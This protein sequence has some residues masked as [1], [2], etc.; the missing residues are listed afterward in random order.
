MSADGPFARRVTMPCGWL[1]AGLAG[2]R[3]T[4]RFGRRFGYPGKADPDFEHIWLTCDACTGCRAVR[5]NGTLLAESP[6]DSF[7]FDV[8]RLMSIRNH[9][10]V[11][12]QGDT[13]D[14]GLW[15][16]V[17]LE[18][19]KDAYLADVLAEHVGSNLL[20]TGKVIGAAPQP[21]EL[22]TLVDKCHAD[23]RTIQPSADGTPFRIELPEVAP[24]NGMVR[25]ELIHVSEIWYVVEL[26]ISH[27]KSA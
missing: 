2:F 5:L 21:L 12:I 24:S 9:L 11:L 22:Y 13:D 27:W 10:E 6:G 14:A 3:G 4:V 8:T 15:G 23:Y 1:G 20:V 19:R 7:A 18:M 25:V 26:P 17:A 16:E